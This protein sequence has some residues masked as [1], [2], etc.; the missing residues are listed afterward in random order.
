MPLHRPVASSVRPSLG[1]SLG[2]VACVLCLLLI[3]AGPLPPRTMNVMPWAGQEERGWTSDRPYFSLGWTPRLLFDQLQP[4]Q[5]DTIRIAWGIDTFNTGDQSTWFADV[6]AMLDAGF[7]VVIS[8]HSH[9]PRSGERFQPYNSSLEGDLPVAQ[10]SATAAPTWTR[11]I[12][13]WQRIARRY[14]DDPRVVGYEPFNEYAPASKKLGPGA[15]YMRDIGGWIDAL[16]ADTLGAGK[17][18]WIEGL[19]ASTH[20]G[21]L[22]GKTDDAGRSLPD[23][24]KAHAGKLLPAVHMYNWYGPGFRRPESVAQ[25]RAALAMEK[26]PAEL[27]PRLQQIADE[28]NATR[29]LQLLHQYNFDMRYEATLAQIDLA[30]RVCGVDDSVQVWMSEAGVGVTSF[31]GDALPDTTMA[32]QFRAI[33]RACNAR[34]VSI[35]FWLDRGR[36]DAWG[37]FSNDAQQPLDDRRREYHQAFFD[38]ESQAIDFLSDPSQM[39]VLPPK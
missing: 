31:T 33:V 4:H 18:V 28:P 35:A 29:Q 8:C 37:F 2:I 3:A 1:R 23:H 7:K 11:F 27:R 38:K 30:R 34:N 6:D 20:F 19:W 39:S 13:D 17:V 14:R 9:V 24:F 10:R 12:T 5:L 16:S 22:E 15:L 21:P 25:V 32:T 36:P 26:L